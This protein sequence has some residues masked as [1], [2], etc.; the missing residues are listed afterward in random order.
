MIGKNN[1]Q[2]NVIINRYLTLLFLMIAASCI[3]FGCGNSRVKKFEKQLHSPDFR[4]RAVAA[5][6]L[7]YTNSKSAV[8]PLVDAIQDRFWEVQEKASESL[9]KLGKFSVE[10]LIPVLEHRKPE[11]RMI[12]AKTLGQIGDQRAVEPLMPLLADFEMDVKIAVAE[13]LG[14]IGDN[15]PVTK[16]ISM[17]NEDNTKLNEVTAEA[18]EKIGTGAVDSLLVALV[19]NENNIRSLIAEILGKIRDPRAVDSL[20]PLLE[21]RDSN[22]RWRAAEA[23]GRIGD[24]RAVEPLIAVLAKEKEGW[25]KNE[26]IFDLG[27]IGDSRA[28]QPLIGIFRCKDHGIR[29]AAAEALGNIGDPDAIPVLVTGLSDWHVS[30]AVINALKKLDWQPQSTRHRVHMMVAKRD[31]KGLQKNWERSQ[32]VLM[33]DLK[34]DNITTIETALYAYIGMGDNEALRDLLNVMYQSGTK[35]LAQAYIN[36]G[37]DEI[38]VL[39]KDWAHNQGYTLWASGKEPPVKWGDWK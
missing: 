34:S 26:L 35:N 31:R 23:L 38:S 4:V 24:E 27:E 21:D 19:D 17:L 8:M 20:I 37:I 11:V 10:P 14:K 39:A 28:T 15:R 9:V 7:G 32:Q 30:N 33:N 25:L 29:I 13:A 36:C 2:L 1:N 3:L 6:S 12:V 22:I 18:L 5:D 16:L